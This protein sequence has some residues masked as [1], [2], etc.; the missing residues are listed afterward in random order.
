MEVLY[1]QVH[2]KSSYPLTTIFGVERIIKV[3]KVSLVFLPNFIV[4]NLESLA[5]LCMTWD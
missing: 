5:M 3:V 2:E 1:I 4:E